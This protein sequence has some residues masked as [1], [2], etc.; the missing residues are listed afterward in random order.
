MSEDDEILP[1]D[2][3]YDE[4]LPDDELYDEIINEMS[5]HMTRFMYYDRKDDERL[6]VGDIESALRRGVVTVDELVE[7]VRGALK[8]G[9]L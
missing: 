1:D 7:I 6:H 4:I 5:D 9:M 2:E 8:R 3:L